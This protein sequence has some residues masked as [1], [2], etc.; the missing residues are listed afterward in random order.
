[1]FRWRFWKHS[2]GFNAFLPLKHPRQ[3]KKIMTQLCT[4]DKESKNTESRSLMEKQYKA[5]HKHSALL[6]SLSKSRRTKQQNSYT[7]PQG[8]FIWP[9]SFPKTQNLRKQGVPSSVTASRLPGLSKRAAFWTG[10]LSVAINAS[11]LCVYNFNSL[12][13]ESAL[14]EKQPLIWLKPAVLQ[15]LWVLSC[16]IIMK[17]TPQEFPFPPPCLL[18]CRK[19]EE[20][21][22]VKG[23]VAFPWAEDEMFQTCPVSV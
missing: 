19:R 13:V 16:Y 15:I 18:Y 23:L 8:S 21:H 1:M 5:L 11:V 9:T 7:E 17:K 12:L 20:K 3:L 14:S 4:Q 10:D 2:K 6:Y 22:K